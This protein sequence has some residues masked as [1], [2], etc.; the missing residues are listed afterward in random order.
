MKKLIGILMSIVL[1]AGTFGA[2]AACNKVEDDPEDI[3]IGIQAQG[4]GLQWLH[5]RADAY[6]AQTGIDVDIKEFVVDG[7]VLSDFQRGA[8]NNNTDIYFASGDTFF[9]QVEE[10]VQNPGGIGFVDLSEVYSAKPEGYEGVDSIEDLLYDYAYE[11]C[12]YNGKPYVF[13]WA[14]GMEGILYHEN[15]LEEHNLRVPRTTDELI[16]VSRAFTKSTAPASGNEADRTQYAFTW[17]EGYWLGR[18]LEWWVQ[19]EGLDV[20]NAFRKGQDIYGNYTPDVYAQ[21][22]RLRSYTVLEELLK[23]SEH[24]SDPGSI[25]ETYTITQ[26]KFLR[27]NALFMPNGDWLEREMERNLEEL[28]KLGVERDFKFMRTPV[29]S[30]ITEKFEHPETWT[31][32]KLRQAISWLDGEEGFTRPAELT[33]KDLEKLK[34]AMSLVEVQSQREVAFVPTYSNNIDGALD[35][36]KF[37][38]SKDS[39]VAIYNTMQGNV[40]PIQYD[41]TGENVKTSVFQQSKYD[42]LNRPETVLVGNDMTH[43]MFYLAGLR[44]MPDI[45]IPLAS[46]PESAAYRDAKALY[47]EYY[48]YYSRNWTDILNTAG[49]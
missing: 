18:Q 6:K 24:C 36:I 47:D 46:R 37:L 40:F 25:S 14:L 44:Y 21:I 12:L 31:D 39:Q 5:E 20:Y 34:E 11:T 29:I 22:G 26:M 41:L 28:D 49:V 9:K 38:Y 13:S 4:Y 8:R 1:A 16:E 27:G 3:Y 15:M 32:E 43:K 33:D 2:L 35:F 45:S 19:Y 7:A 42:L 23:Y 30:A 48:D 17:Y 10:G